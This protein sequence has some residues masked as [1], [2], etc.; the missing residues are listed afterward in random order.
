M[1]SKPTKSDACVKPEVTLEYHRVWPL[2]PQNVTALI[3]FVRRGS[4]FCHLLGAQDSPTSSCHTQSYVNM[5][6]SQITDQSQGTFKF[7][8]HH[9]SEAESR[10]A[11]DSAHMSFLQGTETIYS[12]PVKPLSSQLLTANSLPQNQIS[13]IHNRK[14]H[15]SHCSMGNHPL[16]S[17]K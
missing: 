13:H 9:I 11:L 3:P 8:S 7:Q 12:P 15:F 2:N 4:P 6:M 1:V 17:R 5:T 16:L 14:I 10:V